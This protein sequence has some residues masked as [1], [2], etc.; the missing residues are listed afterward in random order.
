M[1]KPPTDTRKVTLWLTPEQY[2]RVQAKASAATISFAA[3]GR[4]LVQA[5]LD[6]E[7]AK[8]QADTTVTHPTRM[9]A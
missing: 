5:A 3:A 4:Q 6:A 7:D 2:E 8:Q 1:A 9:S